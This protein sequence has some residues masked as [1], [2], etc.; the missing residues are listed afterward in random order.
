MSDAAPDQLAKIIA[1]V[2][3]KC[4]AQAVAEMEKRLNRLRE[5]AAEMCHEVPL[6]NP[7]TGRSLSIEDMCNAAGQQHGM[8]HPMIIS[9]VA[10][11]TDE[12][13]AQFVAN[14]IAEAAEPQRGP[15][16]PRKV[17]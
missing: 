16:R 3:A 10:A 17:A 1:G 7:I 4:K 8:S 9:I 14:G 6:N 2:H 11:R 12:L 13:V 5:F 15:G